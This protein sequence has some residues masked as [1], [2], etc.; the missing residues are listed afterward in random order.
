LIDK[1]NRLLDKNVVAVDI[2]TENTGADINLDNKRIISVQI[3]NSTNVELYY[4]DSKYI[5]YG[6][7]SA[8]ERMAEIL[9]NGYVLTGYNIERFDIPNLAKFLEIQIPRSNFIDLAQTEVI[10]SLKRSQGLYKLEDV[11]SQ[12]GIP[13]K[14]K[15]R[16]NEKA[17]AYKTRPDVLA[18]AARE[19]PKIA[20]K[21][22]GTVEYARTEA[23]A[24]IAVG[25]AILDSYKE[26]VEKE[27][28]KETLFYEYA[29]EDI[30][31]EYHLFE[32]V[33][34]LQRGTF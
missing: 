19:A 13:V 14:H 30:V 7:S 24:K 15:H 16:M 22:G 29:T 33:K 11:C 23:I 5:A 12:F 9:S 17:E 8:K 26:F 6:L 10:R 20:A 31:C 3:G 32:V 21:K 34:Q 25:T 1:N 2:E 4:A 18:L 28:S 27:G